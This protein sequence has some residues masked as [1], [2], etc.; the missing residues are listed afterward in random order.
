MG[1]QQSTSASLPLSP[2]MSSSSRTRSNRAVAGLFFIVSQAVRASPMFKM[3]P[4]EPEEPIGSAGFWWKMVMSMGLVL[5]GGAFAGLTL[6]LM[7]LD[8]LHLRVLATSSDDPNEKKNANKVLR[9]MKKGRHWVLVVCTS[10]MLIGGGVAAVAISTVMI[11]IF[12]IIPQALCARYGLQIGAASAPLVLCMMYIFGVYLVSYR[13]IYADTDL[14]S[15]RQ[16]PLHGLSPSCSIGYLATARPILIKKL[17]SKVS[18]SSIVKV[19]NHSGMTRQVNH[20]Q[21]NRFVHRVES[22]IY[23][24]RL[25][26]LLTATSLYIKDVVTLGSDTILDHKRVDTIGYSRIPVHEPGSPTNFIG[27]LLIKKV[28]QTPGVLPRLGR[29]LFIEFPI[30]PGRLMIFTSQVRYLCRM[31]FMQMIPARGCRSAHS[32]YPFYRKPSPQSAV[33]NQTGRSHLLL[34]SENPGEPHGALGVI[35]L[36]EEI[37]SE[38]IVDETDRYE[39]NRHKRRAKRQSTAAIMRGI[40]ER[41]K[42]RWSFN[43]YGDNAA[44]SDTPRTSSRAPTP[45]PTPSREPMEI[46]RLLPIDEHVGNGHYEGP[47][48]YG[49]TTPVQNPVAKGHA[50]RGR[51]RDRSQSRHRGSFTDSPTARFAKSQAGGERWDLI[52]V[53]TKPTSPVV[54]VDSDSN[55]IVAN[56]HP[57]NSR[58]L[59]PYSSDCSSSLRIDGC[60][61]SRGRAPA[62]RGPTHRGIPRRLIRLLATIHLR[63]TLFGPDGPDD[64]QI[65]F[66]SIGTGSDP[67][68]DFG[69]VRYVNPARAKGRWRTDPY[70]MLGYHCDQ[71]NSTWGARTSDE[72]PLTYV[73]NN[74]LL[75]TINN[76]PNI[77]V[78]NYDSRGVSSIPS[79]DDL[80]GGIYTRGQRIPKGP[81]SVRIMHETAT[82]PSC[83]NLQ[84]LSRSQRGQDADQME[85]RNRTDQAGRCDGYMG[86][87]IAPTFQMS[88]PYP[89]TQYCWGLLVGISVMIMYWPSQLRY[90]GRYQ[91]ARTRSTHAREELAQVAHVTRA[92]M[93]KRAPVFDPHCAMA[94]AGVHTQ[95]Y[96]LCTEY[97]AQS[98]LFTE[99]EGNVPVQH[100]TPRIYMLNLPRRT[101][102]RERMMKLRAATGLSWTFVDSTDSNAEIVTQIMER[103]RWIRAAAHLHAIDS[104]FRGWWS[105][106]HDV[107]EWR[108]MSNDSESEPSSELW[109]LARSD[110]AS[111]DHTHPLPVPPSIDQRPPLEVATSRIIPR[112]GEA[113]DSRQTLKNNPLFNTSTNSARTATRGVTNTLTPRLPKLPY[114]RV[115]TRAAIACWHSHISVIREIALETIQAGTSDAGVII[116]E[117]DIDMEVDIQQRIGRLWE[118][119]PPDW[120]MLFLGQSDWVQ[121]QYSLHCSALRTLLVG[122][123]HLPAP[124][125]A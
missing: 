110:P 53:R 90:R 68:I 3:A 20:I 30:V 47:S 54:Y 94:L 25:F 15:V 75:D 31:N 18:F 109:E 26:E 29:A 76:T 16:L 10:Y 21:H 44:G 19:P 115:L 24:Q 120:D 49:A 85:Y 34:I 89:N 66:A 57:S 5:L 41:E 36:E 106:H 78:L 32:H 112:N 43:S 111:A 121:M 87:D 2:P 61:G 86:V 80:C 63:L 100:S 125:I 81:G 46:T 45:K 113:Q 59:A 91:T 118:A 17:S 40:V 27:I 117:D 51:D 82:A 35:T 56:I 12:G 71:H 50:E 79:R 105:D 69:Q 124:Q 102:R 55:G 104:N 58:V 23:I 99:A 97:E 77:Q 38:E 123:G 13:Y 67:A 42:R 114:W 4:E 62:Q 64:S 93:S 98:G 52:V 60:H 7:G 107:F 108:H 11:V 8:E 6:G 33:S 9:L 95:C 39:D 101:D 122:R 70:Q 96:F 74:D 103:V 48:S 88:E 37:I 72:L 1:Q 119:L 22:G 92:E 73:W 14:G 84:R 83:S 65:F 28:R 116:L